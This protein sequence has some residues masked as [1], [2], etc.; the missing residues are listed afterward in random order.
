MKNDEI[1]FAA[2]VH[3]IKFD[4]TPDISHREKLEQQLLAILENQTVGPKVMW[5]TIMRSHITKLAAA[6]VIILAVLITLATLDRTTTPLWAIEQSIG[7][8]NQYNAVFMEGAQS[9]RLWRQDGN[10]KLR[11]YK[12]WAKANEALTMIEK[13]RIDVDDVTILTTD[14][15]KTW[16]YDPRKNTVR[17][18][19][20]PYV[21]GEIWLGPR[22]LEQLKSFHD[23]GVITNW[24][25]TYG[26]DPAVGKK[27]A[28]LK[29]AWLDKRYNGPRSLS[30]QFN[31]QSK[32]LVALK[33]W[34]NIDCEG[35]PALVAQ[36]ITYYE[37][38]PD[39]LFE[40]HIPEAATVIE[41]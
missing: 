37:D 28:F 17:V 13:F 3:A 22:F 1:K 35:L 15:R 36:K 34:E 26:T 31:M 33:Q 11:P 23:S 40:F 24:E 5:R 2:F 29:I 39:N 8:M 21:A 6:A 27:W 32:L 9:E 7:A 19:N 38:L 30:L 12:S 41:Q 4:D 10:S 16:R 25:I 20:R 14:G 18:Q